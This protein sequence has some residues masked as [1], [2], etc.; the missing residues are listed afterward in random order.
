VDNDTHKYDRRRRFPSPVCNDALDIG[1]LGV[2]KGG[3]SNSGGVPGRLDGGL[4]ESG[5]FKDDDPDDD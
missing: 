1:V 2:Q 3:K 5:N 4:E